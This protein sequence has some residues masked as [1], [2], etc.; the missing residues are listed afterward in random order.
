MTLDPEVLGA[1][2]ADDQLEARVGVTEVSPEAFSR[3]S[4]ISLGEKTAKGAELGLS[5]LD[6]IILIAK[7]TKAGE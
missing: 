7:A 5:L 4:E 2:S 1:F 3:E 6:P